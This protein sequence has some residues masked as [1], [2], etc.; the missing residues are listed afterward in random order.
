MTRGT[1]PTCRVDAFY[2]RPTRAW[3]LPPN[4]RASTIGLREARQWQVWRRAALDR[5]IAPLPIVRI[6]AGPPSVSPSN[7]LDGARSIR[8]LRYLAAPSAPRIPDFSNEPPYPTVTRS[9]RSGGWALAAR[10]ARSPTGV[11]QESAT[12]SND[13]TAREPRRISSVWSEC[14]GLRHTSK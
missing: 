12:F 13:A 11:P 1:E 8:S 10:P 5:V 6:D 3:F 7:H 4:Q 9:H 14:R 2:P